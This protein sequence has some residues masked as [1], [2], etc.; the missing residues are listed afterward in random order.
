MIF[1]SCQPD[2]VYFHWQ[3]ELYLHQFGN[4]KCPRN[5]ECYAIFGYVNKPSDYL[6]YLSKL[7]PNKI[8]YYEYNKKTTYVPSI[9]PYLLSKFYA[10]SRYSHLLSKVFYHDS[11]IFIVKMPNFESLDRLDRL[12]SENV[13]Y[14]SDTIS[15]LGYNYISSSSK[16]YKEVYKDLND[17]DIFYKMCDVMEIDPEL[18][19]NNENNSGGCQYYLKNLTSEFFEKCFQKCEELYQFFI[20][21]DLKYKIKDPIQK[22][23]TDM[24]VMLYQLLKLPNSCVKCTSEFDFSWAV[25]S[26]ETYN[27]RNIFHLAG[28][29]SDN[30][31]DKFFK[32]KYITENVFLAY[33][34]DNTIF[35]HVSSQNATSKYTEQIVQYATKHFKNI[36]YYVFPRKFILN[37]EL[38]IMQ[39]LTKSN[40]PVYFIVCHL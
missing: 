29:T 4:S 6:L 17:N 14:V 8:I 33:L 32:G 25:D 15:Y 26:I 36:K 28:I 34:E 9:R 35:D 38:F 40:K 5:S 30:C 18:V 12:D 1:L 24:W 2:Q 10:D 31:S 37:N 16:K 7:Y 11:D 27:I 3:V 13:H 23:T 39:K 21:Y 19:K 20:D 22:W